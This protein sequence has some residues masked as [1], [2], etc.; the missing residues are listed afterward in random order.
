MRYA[1]DKISAANLAATTVLRQKG[2]VLDAAANNLTELRRRFSPQD[3]ELLDRFNKIT[4]QTAEFTLNG[5]EDA[6]LVEYQLKIKTL[7]DERERIEDEI[8][9]RA[10][11]FFTK[12]QPVTLAAV[13]ALIPPD[14]AL[15][16]FAVYAPSPH[17]TDRKVSS[18]KKRYIAYVLRNQGEV[19]WKDLGDAEEIDAST[20]ALRQA[21]RDPKRKDVPILARAADEKIMQ[22][23]RSLVGDAKQLLISPDGELNLIP[24]EALVDERNH[25]LIEN[26]SFS[27]LTSGRD[28]LRMQTARASKSKSLLVANPMFGAV[29]AEQTVAANQSRKPAAGKNNRRSVTAAR[30]MSDTYFAPL[31]G[32]TEEARFIQTL[33][34]DALFLT[35]TQA[36]ETALKQANAPEILHIATHGFFLEDENSLSDKSAASSSAK[37]NV[38][39]ENSLLRSGL[40]LAG[41]NRRGAANSGDDDGILTALEASGLNLW[42]TKLVVLSACDT[43]LGEIKNGEGVYGL[44]RAFTLAGTETLLMSLWSVSDYATRE[45]MTNYYKNLKR[46]MGRGESLRQTQ[47]EMLRKKGRT[48][49]FFWAGFIQSGEWA[50]L[51]GRR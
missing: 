30:N 23:V 46:G 13:Q 5:A 17:F 24:F 14:S 43:G 15:I 18:D 29:A 4:K 37:A 1:A 51:D 27:Y 19:K 40:A 21:L 39:T 38:E 3:K 28:L 9:R 16:E 31:Q 20:D 45:L 34:P 25:Y 12:S 6:P 11:G 7:T 48:H 41:A 33:F 32:T 36:T 35:G 50:N 8:S 2:R 47:L 22:P 49:P 42:G 26:Y 44:R 10:A